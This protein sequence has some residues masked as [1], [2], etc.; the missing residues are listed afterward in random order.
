MNEKKKMKW[1]L[2]LI[3]VILSIV[4]VIAL[5]LFGTYAY[6][7]YTLKIDVFDIKNKLELLNQDY[8]SSSF[9]TNP[10]D[11]TDTAN[12]FYKLFENENI[13]YSSENGYIFNK[14]QFDASSLVGIKNLSDKE[15]AGLMQTLLS[16]LEGSRFSQDN[17]LTKSLNLKQIKFSNFSSSAQNYSLDITYTLKFNLSANLLGAGGLVNSLFGGLIPNSFYITSTFSLQV[18]EQNYSLTNK[19]FCINALNHEQ[20]A[21]I[22]ETLSLLVDDA[23]SQIEPELNSTICQL[24]LGDETTNGMVDNINDCAGFEFKQIDD[25]IVLEFKKV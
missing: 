12:A 5:L 18:Q 20:S 13:Y 23:L 15:T 1:W 19:S 3:I 25:K 24:L 16:K 2:K 14:E 8:H 9:I 6:L 11:E 17:D 21:S 22:L 7:K 4:A 10:Y